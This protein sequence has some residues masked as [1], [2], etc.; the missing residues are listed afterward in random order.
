MGKY[1]D[2]EL[3]KIQKIS[4]EMAKYFVEFCKENNLICYMCGGGAIG[5]LRNGGFIP[6]DDDLDFFMP[7]E[8]Y[9]VLKRI[10]N[11]KAIK[12][13][14]LDVISPK[15][16]TGDLFINIRDIDTTYIKTYQTELPV[17][18]GV[19][20]DILPLDGYAPE[21]IRRKLQLI[22][23]YV[24]AIFTAQRIPQN[25]GGLKANICKVLLTIFKSKR[26]RYNI[27]KIAEKYM[28][29]YS[30]YETEYT[31][32]LCSGAKYMVKKY[33]SDWFISNRY[34]SFEGTEFPIPIC[35]EEYL[36]TAFGD[37]M[38]LP[39]ED[40]R[41]AHH[42]FKFMDLDTPYNKYEGKYYTKER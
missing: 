24:Y 38:E 3:K 9:E 6:W 4:F 23:A 15:Q 25:H 12:K 26:V 33:K 1:T 7:R 39:P 27:L 16:V 21:G 19:S 37:Y 30:I 18:H 35:A 34:I 41:V 31:T 22:A 8:D 36:K 40:K 17:R 11:K 5:A 10:W 13:Y 42:D 14:R 2:E 20:L 32:E 29:K 28:T